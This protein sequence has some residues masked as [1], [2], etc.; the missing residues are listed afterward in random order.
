MLSLASLHF[1]GRGATGSPKEKLLDPNYIG[2]L[3]WLHNQQEKRQP[4]PCRCPRETE[5]A[6][7]R[8]QVDPEG[9]T[10]RGTAREGTA[11]PHARQSPPSPRNGFLLPA[12]RPG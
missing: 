7:Q 1:S 4:V 10:E 6:F 5:E 2:A 12:Y 3:S 11:E 9:L 8:L